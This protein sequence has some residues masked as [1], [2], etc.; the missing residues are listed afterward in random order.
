VR[1][2]SRSSAK[3]PG[4]AQSSESV[5]DSLSSNQSSQP[6]DPFAWDD[7]D[8]LLKA[9]P[10]ASN[11]R[12]ASND[13]DDDDDDWDG[14]IDDEDQDDDD[15]MAEGIEGDMLLVDDRDALRVG[16]VLDYDESEEGPS[17]SAGGSRKKSGQREGRRPSKKSAQREP[18]SFDRTRG[19]KKSPGPG[20]KKFGS[21]KSTKKAG[22]KKGGFKKGGFKKG[23]P[24]RAPAPRGGRSS[25]GSSPKSSGRGKRRS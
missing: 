11:Q 2:P 6:R 1:G 22:F 18:R 25:K 13:E 15:S 9:S 19:S 3:A 17:K 14:E 10:F 8:E 5:S 23:G 20:K 4:K 7:D 16:R 24:K 12:F 21:A